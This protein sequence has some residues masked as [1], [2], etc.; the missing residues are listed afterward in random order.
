MTFD[1]VMF[2]K[3]MSVGANIYLRLE[4]MDIR[5]NAY[6]NTFPFE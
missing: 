6:S 5:T 4:Q 2:F 1:Q 3:Q